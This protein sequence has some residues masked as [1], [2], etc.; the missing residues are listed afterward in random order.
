MRRLAEGGRRRRG[1]AVP[2]FIG[3]VAARRGPDQRR[4]R[5][6]RGDR[7][8]DRGQGL[9]TNVDGV[10]RVTRLLAR[11]R[12]DGG[13]RFADEA[14]DLVGKRVAWRGRARRAVGTLEIR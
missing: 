13:H 10:G 7:I 11:F 14:N 1:I 8:D 2:D 6:K 12:N 5:G 4:A 3:D 9:V